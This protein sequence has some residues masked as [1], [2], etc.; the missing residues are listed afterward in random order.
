MDFIPVLADFVPSQQRG[1]D[2]AVHI[3]PHDRELCYEFH[4]KRTLRD[5]GTNVYVCC[6][7]S[8]LKTAEEYEHPGMTCHGGAYNCTHSAW[9]EEYQKSHSQGAAASSTAK[10]NRAVPGRLDR[11]SCR[12]VADNEDFIMLDETDTIYFA[13]RSLWAAIFSKMQLTADLGGHEALGDFTFLTDF[14]LPA[15]NAVISELPV[16]VK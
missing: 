13:N 16:V 10:S 12:C 4:Y 15:M 1:R 2:V 7:C 5:G 8:S 9:E 11:A 3:F 14:V 6:G